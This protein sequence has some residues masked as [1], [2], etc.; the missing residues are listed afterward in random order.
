MYELASALALRSY[1]PHACFKKT[2]H[3]L[4]KFH[5]SGLTYRLGREVVPKRGR[6][7]AL[8]RQANL[9]VSHGS[10]ISTCMIVGKLLN[11]KPPLAHYY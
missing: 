11:S 10:I 7:R 6:I 3:L 5:V 2:K 1:L 8:W 4:L 9:G